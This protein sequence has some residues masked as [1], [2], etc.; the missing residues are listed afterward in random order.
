[1]TQQNTQ[2]IRT[3]SRVCVI[4]NARNTCWETGIIEDINADGALINHGS[5]NYPLY[6]KGI[7]V[8]L[9]GLELLEA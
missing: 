2:N 5:R 3:G 6:G 7:R 9:T 8:P 1:M 4:G